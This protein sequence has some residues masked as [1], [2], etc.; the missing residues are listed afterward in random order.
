MADKRNAFSMSHPV[1][2]LFVVIAVIASMGLAAEV[3]K[4]LAL[5]VL[6]AFAL[7]PFARFFERRGLPRVPAVVLTVLIAL[8]G[9]SA[10]GYVVAGQLDHLASDLTDPAH[11]ALIDSKLKFFRSSPESN[12]SK[13]QNILKEEASKLD[14]PEKGKPLA[15]A[16][17]G[18]DQTPSETERL[19]GDKTITGEKIQQVEVVQQPEF[20]ERLQSAVGPFIEVLTVG[21]FV[22]ILVLFMM[23]GRDDLGD[24]IISLFGGKSI[25][26]TTRTMNEVGD[27]IG[28][29]LATNAMVNAGFGIVIGIG[30]HF[31]GLPY[32]VL[33]GVMAALLRFIP[34][35]G[36]VIA[37]S[38]PTLYA[39][40]SFPG[41]GPAMAVVALFLGIETILNS[42]LEPII[43][44]K[45]TGVS[46]LGL[47]VAA[48]FWTWLWGIWGL[49]LS[50]PMTVALA[51]MGKYVPALGFFSKLLGE[52]ADL[53]PDVRYYQRIL[54]LDQDGAAEIVEEMAKSKPRIE[55]FE[56]VLLPALARVE[57]D[58]SREE[59]DERVQAFAW[60]VTDEVLDDL[61]DVPML[62]YATKAGAEAERAVPAEIVGV[63]ANDRADVLAL[64][65]LGQILDPSLCHLTIREDV[66]S[67]LAL[68]DSL[69][70]GD[71]SMVV[72]SHLPPTGLTNARYL[73][74]RIHARLGDLPIVVGRWVETGDSASS[75]ERLTSSGATSVVSTLTAARDAVLA[76]AKPKAATPVEAQ[77][78]SPLAPALA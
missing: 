41:W 61:A 29:Y 64:K 50:T 6:L 13:L 66:E 39:V 72:L 18:K 17:D 46:A 4:P 9:L 42:F 45:T 8:G 33:W 59:I 65:M 58:F 74:K 7:S 67:P 12:V 76:S 36:T 19:A 57:R 62:E 52:E 22:L 75:T 40:A 51:V 1:V 30:V 23:V 48:M 38:L 10:V 37:F 43:Y 26:T 16:T 2:I 20:R 49:L 55:V 21:S 70:S 63:P 31:I 73:V 32:A 53:E 5:S 44:G 3:L 54:A 27:R 35:V 77:T 25:S 14:P 28:R 34:Y 11:K 69:A 60:R 24:R 78:T 71:A 68:S 56:Q 47:L 15:K